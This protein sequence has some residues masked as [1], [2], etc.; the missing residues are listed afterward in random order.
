MFVHSVIAVLLVHTWSL[1][2]RG[3]NIIFYMPIYSEQ[4]VLLLLLLLLSYYSNDASAKGFSKVPRVRKILDDRWPRKL[5]H[6]LNPRPPETLHIVFDGPG[7]CT[8]VKGRCV[9]CRARNK[10]TK[11]L[12]SRSLKLIKRKGKK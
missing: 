12:R 1:A 6:F 10:H 9:Q 3:K 11:N 5:R 7:A 8:I 4:L 2:G